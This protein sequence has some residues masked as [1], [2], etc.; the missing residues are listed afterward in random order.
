MTFGNT[1][2]RKI[3]CEVAMWAGLLYLTANGSIRGLV[4]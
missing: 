1:A 4:D 3:G 2:A